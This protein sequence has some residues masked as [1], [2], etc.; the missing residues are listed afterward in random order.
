MNVLHVVTSISRE[1]SGP[2]QSVPALCSALRDQ[3]VDTT[4]AYVDYGATPTLS[5]PSVHF[6]RSRLPLLRDVGW[7]AG[8]FRYIASARVD[9]I[10]VHGL[11]ELPTIMPIVPHLAR[12]VPLVVS[13]RGTLGAWALSRSPLKKRMALLLGQRRVLESAAFLHATSE[14]EAQEFR[15]FGLRSPIVVAPNVVDTT[16]RAS[17][18]SAA[19]APVVLFL[20]RLHPKKQ[21]EVLLH[22]WPRIC[23]AVPDVHLEVAGPDEGGYRA[24]LEQLATRLSLR[25]V[26]FLGNLVGEEKRKAFERADVFALPTRNENF[27]MVVAEAALA[28]ALVVCS[29]G[30]PWAVLEQ[31]H[32]GR[33]VHATPD[34]FAEA[35]SSLLT[36]PLAK[37]AEMRG[38]ARALVISRFGSIA[39]EPLVSA[40]QHVRFGVGV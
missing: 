31:E 8:L 39:A 1:A 10:H 7:S 15:E 18:L 24:E 17:G 33:W 37:K 23:A 36:M 40:Y 3:G 38:R 32:A 4:L 16:G 25:N 35:I 13:P 2:S 21:V 6:R 29:T 11:W 27:G 30:A 34:T 19:R 9:V 20:S 14:A 28:G 12:R 26:R 5:T 22:A